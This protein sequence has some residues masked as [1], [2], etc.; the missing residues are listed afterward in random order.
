MALTLRGHAKN[1]MDVAWSPDDTLLASAS[2]D[3]YVFVW[4]ASGARVATLP[5]A[6]SA[7]SRHH[8]KGPKKRVARTRKTHTQSAHASPCLW[9]LQGTRAS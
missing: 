8:R 2:L 7:R 9:L 4:D 3:N 6:C 1:V 5:G